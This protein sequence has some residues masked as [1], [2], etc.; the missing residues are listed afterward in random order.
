MN[1][2]PKITIEF[3][4]HETHRYPTVGDWFYNEDGSLTIRVSK[5]GDWKRECLVAVHELVEVLICRSNG[6]SQ[7]SVDQFDK[8]FEA[9]RDS[10]NEDEPGDEPSAPYVHEHCIATGVER[11]LA[12]EL[13]VSWKLYE[14]ELMALP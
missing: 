7:E 13:G 12:A 2:I 8:D 11:I 14:Q 1:A 5:L 10:D 4:E 9:A 3:I 6:V